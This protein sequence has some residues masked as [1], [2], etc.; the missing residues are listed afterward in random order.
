MDIKASKVNICLYNYIGKKLYLVVR[1][2]IVR[3]TIV[4]QIEKSL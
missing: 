2:N 3:G 4:I 1:M